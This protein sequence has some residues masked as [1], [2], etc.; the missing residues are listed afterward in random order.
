M[1]AARIAGASLHVH[2]GGHAF[3]AQDRHASPEVLDV[4]SA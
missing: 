1:M 4:L 3:F 2:D